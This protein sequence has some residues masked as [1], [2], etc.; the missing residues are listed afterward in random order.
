MSWIN[1]ILTG[2]QSEYKFIYPYSDDP[3]LRRAELIQNLEKGILLED[4]DIFI[5][6]NEPFSNLQRF[7]HK[8]QKDKSYKHN[9]LHIIVDGL[10][11]GLDPHETVTNSTPFIQIECFLGFDDDGHERYVQFK[12]HI[13][14]RFGEPSE[15]H[16][17]LSYDFH[18]DISLYWIYNQFQILLS[19][20]ERF[21]VH[22]SFRIEAR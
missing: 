10:Q 21:A 14:N 9:G 11:V 8:K 13:V 17:G 16:D 2:K 7:I 3:T 15:T 12:N 20:W 5:R 1:N 22:Y 18:G 19:V 4:L 6:W